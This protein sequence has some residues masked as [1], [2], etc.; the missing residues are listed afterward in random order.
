MGKIFFIS[1]VFFLILF[2]IGLYLHDT[3]IENKTPIDNKMGRNLLGLALIAVAF[4][5]L[6]LL[7]LMTSP[8]YYDTNKYNVVRDTT[9]VDGHNVTYYVV[10]KIKK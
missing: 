1:G 9:V 7:P 8:H 10:D 4:W 6:Y 5:C 2:V 3:A